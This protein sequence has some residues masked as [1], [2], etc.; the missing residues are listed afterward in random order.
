MCY[1]KQDEGNVFNCSGTN[2]SSLP[3]DQL[4]L[5]TTNILDCSRNNITHLKDKRKYM[6]H[7]FALN[8]SSSNLNDIDGNVWKNSHLK[9]LDL[10]GNNLTTLPMSITE[11]TSLQKIWLDG[12]PFHC[13]CDIFTLRDWMENFNHS[14]TRVV[15][16]YGSISCADNKRIH[17]LDP[18]AMGCFPKL[19]LWQKIALGVGSACLVSFFVIAILCINRRLEEIQWLLFLK[20]NILNKGDA[21][22]NLDD[23][24]TDAYFCFW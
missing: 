7:L 10:R 22:E 6:Q 24:E 18:W 16:D 2:R 17:S 1:Y 11:L 23:K 19:K 3:R 8:L 14:G 15:Q 9:T 20:F 12:N 21:E 5:R 4:L 13:D